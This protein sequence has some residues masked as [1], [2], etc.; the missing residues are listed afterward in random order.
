M[1]LANQQRLDRLERRTLMKNHISI[2]F[3]IDYSSID[4]SFD[5]LPNLVVHVPKGLR[6]TFTNILDGTKSGSVSSSFL[7]DMKNHFSVP[8]SGPVN[9]MT[10]IIRAMIK[11]ELVGEVDIRYV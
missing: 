11:E 6:E 5:G 3:A 1:E 4:E 7:R 2:N 10:P 8:L 9:Y